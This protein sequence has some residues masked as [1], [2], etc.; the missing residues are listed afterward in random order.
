MIHPE[1]HEIVGHWD[2]VEGRIHADEAAVRI[3]RL[4]AEHLI[5]VARDAS[6]WDVLYRDPDDGRYWELT[7]PKSGMH[8]GGPP[9]LVCLDTER[10]RAKYGAAA[11]ANRCTVR[12]VRSRS[13]PGFGRC[14]VRRVRGVLSVVSAAA[15]RPVL[16]PLCAR[17]SSLA[18]S[19]PPQTACR[20]GL[21]RSFPVAALVRGPLSRAGHDSSRTASSPLPRS[22][23]YVGQK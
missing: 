14:T 21:D 3:K 10:S 15:R 6:G 1:E 19:S 16:L 4:I 11:W 18:A 20:P 12:R 8:G 13:L 9:M 2:L 23:P 7:Y 22:S 17:E 5:L